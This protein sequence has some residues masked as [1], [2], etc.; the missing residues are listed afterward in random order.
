MAISLG[1]YP[2]FSD[3]S[4]YSYVLHARETP[5]IGPWSHRPQEAEAVARDC[6]LDVEQLADE[7]EL[8]WSLKIPGKMEDGIKVV[9]DWSSRYSKN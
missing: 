2:T 4:I 5:R 1:I 7:V 9:F 8:F 6:G 3:I